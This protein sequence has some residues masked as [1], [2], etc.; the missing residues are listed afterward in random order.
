MNSNFFKLKSYNVFFVQKSYRSLRFPAKKFTNCYFFP[1][2]LSHF[3]SSLFH[4]S[5]S[6][7]SLPPFSLPP[8]LPFSLCPSLLYSLSPSSPVFPFLGTVICRQQPWQICTLGCIKFLRCKSPT[9]IWSGSVLRSL[10]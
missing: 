1:F 9:T 2:P 3:P 6:P 8:F 7:F 4:F 10:K 5:L